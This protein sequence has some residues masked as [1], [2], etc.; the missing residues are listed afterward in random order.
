MDEIRLVRA[1]G[2]LV[3]EFDGNKNPYVTYNN[4]R[5]YLE[6]VIKFRPTL[7]GTVD[8]GDYFPRFIEV[9]ASG[10]EIMLYKVVKAESD[11][12]FS[13]TTLRDLKVRK[14]VVAALERVGINTVE[15]F[16]NATSDQLE[17][18]ADGDTVLHT[19]ILSNLGFVKSARK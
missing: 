1:S 15:E 19:T 11:S 9:S 16:I 13:Q 8:W 10:R 2:W 4:D 7:P 5:I 14:D 18:A 17:K 12:N 3:I 6:D